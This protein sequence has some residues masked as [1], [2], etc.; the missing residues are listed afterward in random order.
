M[1]VRQFAINTDPH[2]FQVGDTKLLLE[3]EVEGAV[4]AQAYAELREVQGKVKGAKVVA[5]KGGHKP[6]GG[7][8]DDADDMDPAVLIQLNTA[9]R[10]FLRGFMLPDSVAVFDGMRLPDRVL[11]EMMEAVA[12]LYGSGSQGKDQADDDGGPSSD[13]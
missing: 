3:P 10:S 8:K 2:V 5:A 4:F 12:E 13:A 11:V 6:K 7:G 1:A 9:M